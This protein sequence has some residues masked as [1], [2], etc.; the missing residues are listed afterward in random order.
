MHRCAR[1]LTA[2]PA[3]TRFLDSYQAAHKLTT[4]VEPPMDIPERGLSIAGHP[5][6]ITYKHGAWVLPARLCELG[7]IEAIRVLGSIQFTS[8][9]KLIHCRPRPQCQ[10]WRQRFCR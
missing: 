6:R 7:R 8:C 5:A 9:G 10:I 4:V 3:H 2:G 1:E